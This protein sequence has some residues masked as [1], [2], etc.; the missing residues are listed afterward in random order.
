MKAHSRLLRTL[1]WLIPLSASLAAGAVARADNAL[2]DAFTPRALG[3]GESLRGAATGS[4]APMNPAGLALVHNYSVEGSYGYSPAASASVLSAS[5]ADS[6]TR[7]GMALYY[8][9]LSSSNDITI[10]DGATSHSGTA[11]R[12]RHEFGAA[13]SFPISDRF[14]LGLTPKYTSYDLTLDDPMQTKQTSISS[15]SR[16]NMDV[17]ALIGLTPT[18]TLGLVGYNLIHH[19]QQYPRALGGGL[20]FGLSNAA[21]LAADAVVDMTSK[22]DAGDGGKGNSVRASAGT[23]LVLAGLYPVRAGVIYDSRDRQ[24]FVTGGLGYLSPRVGIDLAIRQEVKGG[25]ET[26]GIIGLKFFLPDTTQ[27]QSATE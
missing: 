20:A 6:T 12:K 8:N 17:G 14:V 4:A 10:M 13:T 18:F 23:E 25:S 1:R 2:D 16:F 21:M 24:T 26:V 19:D 7:V 22:T 27:P 5:V 15:H 11:D 3:M 9:L